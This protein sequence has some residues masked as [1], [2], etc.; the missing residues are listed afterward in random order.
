MKQ[1]WFR[2]IHVQFQKVVFQIPEGSVSSFS[3]NYEGDRCLKTRSSTKDSVRETSSQKEKY[4]PPTS[5]DSSSSDTRQGRH[6]T[7]KPMFAHSD[8]AL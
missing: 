5:G 2:E 4:C 8:S 3:S 6:C 1:R 7:T